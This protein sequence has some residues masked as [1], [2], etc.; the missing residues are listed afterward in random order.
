MVSEPSRNVGTG[1]TCKLQ[2]V[3]I[4][5]KRTLLVQP[6]ATPRAQPFAMAHA[7]NGNNAAKGSA[8]CRD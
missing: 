4:L 5:T 7:V 3:I 2:E 6:G 1:R 8:T